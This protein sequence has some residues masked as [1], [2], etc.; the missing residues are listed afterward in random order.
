MMNEH[1]VF[2]ATDSTLPMAEYVYKRLNAYNLSHIFV[3]R[4]MANLTGTPLA[5][6]AGDAI[7]N[8][9]RQFYSGIFIANAG[10]EPEHGNQLIKEGAADLVAFARPYIVNPDLVERIHAGAPH[11][12]PRK[13]YF[14]GQS[15]I[16]YTDYPFLTNSAQARTSRSCKVSSTAATSA[17]SFHRNWPTVQP[18]LPNPCRLRHTQ[19]LP[20][21]GRCPS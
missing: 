18:A 4:Q 2:K 6:V 8:H 9:M 20:P 1:G 12:V 5:H 15:P 17:Q 13:E 21:A 14:Y 19:R 16:G 10:I 11:E 3:M 7:L